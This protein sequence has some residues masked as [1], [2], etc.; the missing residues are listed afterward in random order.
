MS[1]LTC[2]GPKSSSSE[3]ESESEEEDDE[4]MNEEEELEVLVIAGGTPKKARP[5]PLLSVFSEPVRQHILCL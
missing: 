5:F 3:E 2:V 4:D 1:A